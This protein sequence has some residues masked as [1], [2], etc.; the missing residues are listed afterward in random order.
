[1]SYT[2]FIYALGDAIDASFSV[3]RMLGGGMPFGWFNWVLTF[4]GIALMA[5]WMKQMSGHEEPEV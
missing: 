5:W 3:L 2:E 4:V 1:M